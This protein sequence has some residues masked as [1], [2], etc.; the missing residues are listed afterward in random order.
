MLQRT[1]CLVLY[2]WRFVF[3]L[4]ITSHFIPQIREFSSGVLEFLHILLV[5][6]DLIISFASDPLPLPFPQD[7]IF[8]P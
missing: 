8:S 4:D 7:L 1:S 3:L 6:L 2:I 5:G